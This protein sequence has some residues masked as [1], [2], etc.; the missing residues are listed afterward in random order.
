MSSASAPSGSPLRGIII[1]P[2]GELRPDRIVVADRT[3]FLRDR[4]ACHYSVGVVLEVVYTERNG[5]AS[6]EKI[7]PVVHVG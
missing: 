1:G 7:T 4:E 2:L 3:L 5:R 6:V